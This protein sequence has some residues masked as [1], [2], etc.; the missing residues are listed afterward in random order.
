MITKKETELQCQAAADLVAEAGV[1]FL[2]AGTEKLDAA[3]WLARS[4]AELG[5]AAADL[6][7]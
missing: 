2:I 1:Q 5:S 4:A 6:L 3:R 7:E